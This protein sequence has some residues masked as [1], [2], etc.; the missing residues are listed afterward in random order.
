MWLLCLCTLAT[1]LVRAAAAREF[2]SFDF[3]AH[4]SS[5]PAA[6]LTAYTQWH[7]VR[8][9]AGRAGGGKA[10]G[11]GYEIEIAEM[12]ASVPADKLESAPRARSRLQPDRAR[13][14]CWRA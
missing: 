4:K 8:M 3:A 11:V 5:A 10:R 13:R 2:A 7:A 6:L 9:A 1:L 14:T 12:R